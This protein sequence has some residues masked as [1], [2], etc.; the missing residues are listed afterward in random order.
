MYIIALKHKEKIQFAEFLEHIILII[1]I[2]F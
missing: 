1:Q 2:K